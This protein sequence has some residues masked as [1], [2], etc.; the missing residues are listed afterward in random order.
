MTEPAAHAGAEDDAEHHAGAR[1]GAVGGLGEGEA[2]GVVHHPHRAAEAGLEV[3]PNG[4]PLIQVE[5][6]FLTDAGG[7]D[8]HPR[9]ADADGAAGPGGR[10]EVGDD[11]GDGVERPL[12]VARRVDA[13]AGELAPVAASA[14]PSVLVPPRSM[15]MRM[16]VGSG[17]AGF[18]GA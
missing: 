13:E 2:V 4:R 18:A 9:D 7:R 17:A 3:A 10:L 6:E 12:V 8:D 15:P 16:G 11:A 5:F 1:A 14:T